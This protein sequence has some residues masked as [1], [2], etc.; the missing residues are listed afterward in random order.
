[1]EAIVSC[2]TYSIAGIKGWKVRT[3]SLRAEDFDI[4]ETGRA[5][6]ASITCRN[7]LCH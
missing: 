1:M 2:A 5:T 7:I 6:G 4:V 3:E